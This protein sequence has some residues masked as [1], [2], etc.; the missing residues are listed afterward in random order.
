M[1][2]WLCYVLYIATDNLVHLTTHHLQ[3]FLYL[4]CCPFNIG[5]GIILQSVCILRVGGW[6]LELEQGL[7]HMIFWFVVSYVH[8]CVAS[9][10]QD[11]KQQNMRLKVE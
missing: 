6:E 11:K 10:K 4:Y 8:I 2:V 3:V 7:N 9:E 5:Y 1:I